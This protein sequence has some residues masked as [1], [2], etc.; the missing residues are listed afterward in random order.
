M[1][2]EVT[3]RGRVLPIGGL[4]EKA[5]AAHRNRITT[6]LIPAQNLRDVEEMPDEVKQGVA[7][8]PMKT[9]DEVLALALREAPTPRP[10]AP[11]AGSFATL[12]PQ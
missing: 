6:V 3:L 12:T 4:K 9:M 10:D 1:T 2:G 7:F 11:D 8:H 5:V